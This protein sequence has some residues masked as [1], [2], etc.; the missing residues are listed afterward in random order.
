MLLLNSMLANNSF[1]QHQVYPYAFVEQAK[2]IHVRPPTQEPKDQRP[3]P[4]LASVPHPKERSDQLRK[5]QP[6]RRGA[7]PA[8]VTAAG[9]ELT[10]EAAVT[11]QQ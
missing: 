9:G 10:N 1:E 6:G 11:G 3:I 4:R 8:P 5:V 7:V 2:Q